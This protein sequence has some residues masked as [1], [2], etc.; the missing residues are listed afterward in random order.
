M[1]EYMGLRPPKLPTSDASG[2]RVL[3]IHGVQ[4]DPQ[5]YKAQVV[6]KAGFDVFAPNMGT[7]P[8]AFLS[9]LVLV[10][11]ISLIGFMGSYVYQRVRYRPQKERAVALV[12][13]AL[14]ALLLLLLFVSVNSAVWRWKFARCQQLIRVSIEDFQ[15]HAIV[16]SSFG[17]AVAV[18]MIRTGCWSGPTVLLSPAVDM[19]HRLTRLGRGE[20]PTIPPGVPV[21]VV[22]GQSDWIAPFTDAIRLF[23]ESKGDV[24]FID[25]ESDGH[26]LQSWN[27]PLDMRHLV[28]ETL[29]FH[30]DDDSLASS[31]VRTQSNA[32]G[33]AGRYRFTTQIR[34]VRRAQKERSAAAVT[35]GL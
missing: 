5:Q 22:H 7:K 34:A 17:A 10:L 30:V 23:R 2:V 12:L 19:V 6:A 35:I 14:F 8:L 13:F 28:M 31:Y 16:A 32:S 29:S 3:F 4:A 33:H 9:I 18:E 24:H 15:P 11:L 26:F 1:L 25:A 27:D 21:S 20:P